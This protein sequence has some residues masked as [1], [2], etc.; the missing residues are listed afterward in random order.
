[1]RENFEQEN[2]VEGVEDNKIKKQAEKSY[3]TVVENQIRITVESDGVKTVQTANGEKDGEIVWKNDGYFTSWKS[4]FKDVHNTL[5]TQHLLR[6][7]NHSLLDLKNILEEKY[8][9]LKEEFSE[10]L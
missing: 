5:V 9:F 1:M 6:K 3:I 4:L 7:A 2:E 8:K 10:Y